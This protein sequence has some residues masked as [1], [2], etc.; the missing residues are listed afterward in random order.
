MKP[1][2]MFTMASCPYC[3]QAHRWMDE[4]L[5]AHPEYGDIPLEI[6][7][8]LEQPALAERYTY[9]YVPTYY[10]GGVK[11]HEGVANKGIVLSVFE[12]AFE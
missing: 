5:V 1:I 12:R 9:Y 6:V 2:L 7:D 4:V 8:E 11:V 10:V 3:R